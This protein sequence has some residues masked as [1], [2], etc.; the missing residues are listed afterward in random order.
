LGF[1]KGE[2]E[3]HGKG[4]NE[5]NKRGRAYWKVG[6]EKGMLGKAVRKGP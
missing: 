2:R 4:I 5:L 3:S 6:E 1:E